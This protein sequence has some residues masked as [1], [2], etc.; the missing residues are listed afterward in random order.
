MEIKEEVESQSQIGIRSECTMKEH[1]EHDVERT[2]LPTDGA[3][4]M[5]IWKK[6]KVRCPPYTICQN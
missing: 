6:N 3:G 4:K 1:L 2:D 5:A